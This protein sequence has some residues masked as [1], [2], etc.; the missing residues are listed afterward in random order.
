[1]KKSTKS[2]HADCKFDIYTHLILA[3]NN[4]HLQTKQKDKWNNHNEFK[5]NSIIKNETNR[6]CKQ[7]NRNEVFW[8]NIELQANEKRLKMK[9]S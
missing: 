2:S 5:L 9:T 4:Q 1:M 8:M 6:K 7:T 3:E